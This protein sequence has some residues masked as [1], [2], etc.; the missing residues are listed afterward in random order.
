MEYTEKELDIICD[1]CCAVYIL[2]ASSDKKIQEE[3]ENYFMNNYLSVLSDLHIISDL[4]EKA[5]LEF[6]AQDRFT[7]DHINE[8]ASLSKRVQIELVRKGNK[9]VARKEE[10]DVCLQYKQS[11]H[12]F[13]CNISR[14]SRAFFGLGAEVSGR[15][16]EMMNDLRRVLNF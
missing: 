7:K 2:I 16:K 6:W 12:K 3:E 9:L 15:E 1:S 14:E 8:I 13:A 4:R 10:P 5:V 11:L